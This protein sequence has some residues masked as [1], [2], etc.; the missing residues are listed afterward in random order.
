MVPSNFN[1]SINR[2]LISLGFFISFDSVSGEETKWIAVGELHN[3]FSEAGCEIETAGWTSVAGVL[4][5]SGQS[6]CKSNVAWGC[7]LF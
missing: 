4:F 2:I 6:S 5:S 1:N 7:E 3:W